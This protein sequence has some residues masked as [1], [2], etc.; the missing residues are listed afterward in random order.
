MRASFEFLQ[1]LKKLNLVSKVTRIQI[2]LYG[3]LALTGRGHGTDGAVLAGL[4]GA[5]PATVSPDWV[6]TLYAQTTQ[7]GY[8]DLGLMSCDSHYKLTFNPENDLLFLYEKAL[9]YH[10]NAIEYQAYVGSETVAHEIF[11]SIG[12]GAIEREGHQSSSK[13]NHENNHENKLP[14][15]FQSAKQLLNH[16]E[17]KQLSIAEIM[18]ANE[19]INL[20]ELTI[21]K[22]LN[23]IWQAMN[24][25]IDRGL[26]DDGL[27]PGGLNVK[28]R[29]KRLFEKINKKNSR[30]E[31]DNLNAYSIAVN[32]ENAMGH[33]VVT[34]PTNGAAGV[35][36]AVLRLYLEQQAAIG[37]PLKPSKPGKL[38][39]VEEF[40]LTAAAIG[41]LYQQGASI[42]AAEVG[43]QGEIGV[44]CSM[45][46]GA[47]TA[48]SGGNVLQVEHAAEMAM[49]HHLGLTCDPIGGLVQIPCIER[50]A[51]ASVQAVNCT[52]IALIEEGQ[53]RVTLDQV[54]QTMMETGRD[55]QTRY[56]ETAQGGLAVNVPE[57]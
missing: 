2:S 51:M 20:D 34:A 15:M 14:F 8:I 38:N 22:E 43:C 12:G 11:Y 29:A 27:L 25:S 24:A 56:K 36:P 48:V 7:S 4:F 31:F 18:M 23:L 33:R 45:A 46:A 9:D 30:N 6:K 32:E 19:L 44:A 57:C 39:I 26:N 54:I 16:C 50:N 5:L 37:N 49:E 55:M 53:H 52:R 3:S 47:L 10:S 42:S 17:I 41:L 13:N 35:I 21:K 1:I 28:R 40:L